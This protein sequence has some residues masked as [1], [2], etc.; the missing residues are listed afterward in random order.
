MHEFNLTPCGMWLNEMIYGENSYYQKVIFQEV[1]APN[2]IIWHHYSST[3]KNWNNTPNPMM[4]NWPALLLTTV[5]FEDQG[6]QTNVI[7]TQTPMDAS[8]AEL[9]CFAQMMSKM[10]G[11]WGS[12]Y[13]IIDQ[14]LDELNL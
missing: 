13:N 10:D 3:D 11:G 7:L 12:G 2:K 14:I 5:I 4:A 6:E 1:D 8:E 9:T